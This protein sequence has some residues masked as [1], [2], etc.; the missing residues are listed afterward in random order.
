MPPCRG[1]QI[2]GLLLLGRPSHVGVFV[3]VSKKSKALG[4]LVAQCRGAFFLFGKAQALHGWGSPVI[5]DYIVCGIKSKASGSL[6]DLRRGVIYRVGK[7]MGRGST[8]VRAY[9][10][11]SY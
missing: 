1:V 7:I 9:C 5:G 8:D 3:V 10:V 11:A 6:D 2:Q 4:S